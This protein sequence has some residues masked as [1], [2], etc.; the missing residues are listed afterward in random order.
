MD[1]IETQ[2]ADSTQE[3]QDL[4]EGKESNST[5]PQTITLEEH[6]KGIEDAIAQYGD[7]IKQ[8]KIDP[9]ATERDGFKSQVEQL[10]ADAEDA[11][12][13]K[14]ETEARIS[15]L[16]ADLKTA[17]EGFPDQD[18]IRR[19]KID[20]HTERENARQER[21]VEKRANA[22]LKRTLEREREE[23]AGTVAEAQSAKFEVDVLKISEEYVDEAGK[24]I[25][26]ERL[27]SLCEK[28]GVKKREDIQGLADV[29]WTKKG[30]E[31]KP[32]LE[33]DSSVTD[34]VGGWNLDEH[35]P[36]ENIEHGLEKKRKQKQ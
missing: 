19:I 34:G 12:T 24:D 30:K 11:T 9:I 28:A 14:E 13:D 31:E 8:E 25:K 21:K 6:K 7:R 2:T 32:V 26:S 36:K 3:G 35:T 10:K 18:E 20:L 33:A 5:T 16:E 27:K 17:T 29:L 22:E 15:S 23:W 1:E 4:P